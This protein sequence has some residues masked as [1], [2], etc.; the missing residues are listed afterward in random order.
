[1]KK[2]TL[3]TACLA[4]AFATSASAQTQVIFW[5]G[6]GVVTG[7][8]N[9]ANPASFSPN[10]IISPSSNYTAPAFSGGFFHSGTGGG[11]NTWQILANQAL[12]GAS[13][14][15]WI[16]LSYATNTTS[17]NVHQALIFFSQD[18]FADGLNTGLIGLNSTTSLSFVA[19][20]TGGLTAE[21]QFRFV[22]Q[23][24]SSYYITNAFGTA[25]PNGGSNGGD[26]ISLANPTTAT[27]FNFTPETSVASSSIG[28]QAN[29]VSDGFISGV[30]GIGLWFNNSRGTTSG[31]LNMNI[32][33]ITFN[34]V[35][36]PE[37]SA[38]AALLGLG[39][40]G[41][42]ATRRRRRS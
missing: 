7:N 3:S 14:K 12:G 29:I 35:V 42:A 24:G 37:P 5:G 22:V 41:C 40:L 19:R 17:T 4:I 23:I 20:R 38:F 33:D 21:T 2:I 32:T 1:M 18:V 34:A 13:N 8:A 28:S 9:L 36:I 15:D 39:A 11:A 27:W 30:T 31:T 10:E 26:T 16:H 6:D 25:A